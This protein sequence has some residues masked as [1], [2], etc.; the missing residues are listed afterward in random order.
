M[1]S[2]LR[3]VLPSLLLG[4]LSVSGQAASASLPSV[5][6]QKIVE[7]PRVRRY[8]VPCRVVWQ[9][10]GAT[11]ENTQ[12]LLSAG[13]GQVTLDNGHAC[14]L[15]EGGGVLVDFGRELQG[16]VQIMV[17]RMKDQTPTRLRVRFSESV[18]EAMS[19]IGGAT[20]AT[21]DHAIRDQSV[22][23]PWLEPLGPG[24]ATYSRSRTRPASAGPRLRVCA[25][26]FRSPA[27]ANRRRP[28]W[29]WPG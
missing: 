11:V 25:G 21:N 26:R 13:R 16:G 19:D 7:D 24:S 18:S 9:S 23:A 17:G 10:P 22:L 29:R 1:V 6:A 5:A 8:V 27:R 14:V 15:H 12:A 20:N 4:F 2:S 3:F 28:S